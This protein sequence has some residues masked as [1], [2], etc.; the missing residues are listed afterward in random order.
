MLGRS[1]YRPDAVVRAWER[2]LPFSDSWR[3][4]QLLPTTMA[5]V[6]SATEVRFPPFPAGPPP[7]VTIT[8]FAQWQE[9]GILKETLDLI[10]RDA[11]GIPTVPMGHK[12]QHATDRCKS[13]SNQYNLVGKDPTTRKG[14][15]GAG[16]ARVD[17]HEDWKVL[18]RYVQSGGYNPYVFHFLL[19]ANC[20]ASLLGTS[21][22]PIA[23]VRRRRTMPIPGPG[24]K[25]TR[26]DH[27]CPSASNGTRCALDLSTGS[28]MM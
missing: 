1:F 24:P 10:E 16:A 21:S 12:A 4:R 28:A 2:A 19:R 9:T 14:K 23:F 18:E 13:N 8:P 27:P 20:P 26:L 11:L 3:L 25:R 5:V 22:S 15:K 6:Q 17:W 7:G